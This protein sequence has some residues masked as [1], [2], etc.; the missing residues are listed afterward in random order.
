MRWPRS[1]RHARVHAIL[2]AVVLWI[3][4]AVFGLAGSSD[5]SIAGPLKGADFVHFYTLGHLVRTH[6]TSA[7]YD[8]RAVYEAQVALVPESAPDTYPTVYPPQ[9]AI[10]FAA[11]SA[12]SF[13]SAL[14]LWTTITVVLYVLIVWTAWRRSAAPRLD[15]VFV[16]AAAAGFPP[17]WSLVIHGQATILILVAFWLGWL[18]LERGWKFLAGV[19]FGLLAIKPQFG[20]PLATIVVLCGEWGMLAGAIVSVIVQGLAVWLTLGPPVLQAFVDSIPVTLSLADALE[21]KP[22]QSHSLR[23]M[24]RL[25]PVWLGVPLWGALSAAV[26][27]YTVRVWRTPAPVGVRVGVMILASVLVNPHVIVYDA[28]VLALPL[29]WFAAY[30]HDP[31]RSGQAAKFWIVIYW[32]FP[33]LLMPTARLIGIQGSV[34]LMAW[35]L[36]MMAR[37]ALEGAVVGQFGSQSE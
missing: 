12:W 33:L 17:F 9:T 35:L 1:A 4:A 3:A 13:R 37:V 2:L 26:L 11:L 36:V 10:V 25:L 19:A 28:T 21:P 14:L 15:P 32:L 31:V 24:T 18:A 20:V 30:M 8:A 5:R 7:L 27:W 22:Y 29:L 34:V 16:A 6:G 23:A